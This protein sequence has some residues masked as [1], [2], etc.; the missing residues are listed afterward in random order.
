MITLYQDSFQWFYFEPSDNEYNLMHT[1]VKKYDTYYAS[2]NLDDDEGFITRIGDF[3][4]DKPYTSF[5]WWKRA[6]EKEFKEKDCII[7]WDKVTE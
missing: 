3:G 1:R 6:I 7:E 5:T 4:N 2:F